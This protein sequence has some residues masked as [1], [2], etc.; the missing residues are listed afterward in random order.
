MTWVLVITE[1]IKDT[2]KKSKT[3]PTEQSFQH[4]LSL[5]EISGFFPLSSYK[6]EGK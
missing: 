4:K 3:P 6:Y 5:V 2:K 1:K